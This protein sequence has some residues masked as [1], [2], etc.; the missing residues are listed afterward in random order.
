LVGRPPAAE[1]VLGLR[2]LH[3]PITFP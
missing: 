2:I 3:Q 1:P